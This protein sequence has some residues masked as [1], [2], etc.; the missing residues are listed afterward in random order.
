MRRRDGGGIDGS[1]PINVFHRA[2]GGLR[3]IGDL[4][5]GGNGALVTAEFNNQATNC[6]RSK[7]W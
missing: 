2:T 3:T 5:G 1:N 6:T 4:V 7:S